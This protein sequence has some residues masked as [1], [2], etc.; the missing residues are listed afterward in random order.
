MADA[1]RPSLMRSVKSA[2]LKVRPIYR[3]AEWRR[4]YS[5]PAAPAAD[6]HG[7][8]IP[9]RHLMMMVAGHAD[10]SGFLSLGADTVAAF[11]ALLKAQG[12]GF[13]TAERILDWGCGCGRLARHLPRH[14]GA[15]IVGV[16]YNPTLVKWCAEH[17]PGTY[18]KNE[19]NPPLPLPDDH[20]DLVF[21]LS[22]LTHLRWPTQQAWLEELAR[23][24]RPGGHVL[25]TFHDHTHP[26][27]TPEVAAALD[28]DGFVVVNEAH[29]GSNYL[30]SFQSLAQVEREFSRWFDVLS[31]TPA[32]DNVFKQGAVVMRARC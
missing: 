19:L 3:A 2:L 24:C 20:V 22:V 26:N 5:F 28:R 18:L 23:V 32:E 10:W 21:A 6:E 11:D 1:A 15:E 8:P 14:T 16:D 17:L 13:D 30:A 27:C 29:E 9:N 12:A 4:A 31:V 7:L 25:L